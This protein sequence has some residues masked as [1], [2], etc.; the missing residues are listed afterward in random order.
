MRWPKIVLI[1]LTL[2]PAFS[3]V[4][5]GGFVQVH[6][7]D[8]GGQGDV[9]LD[10]QVEADLWLWPTERTWGVPWIFQR[11]I[12]SAPYT[13]RLQVWDE[14]SWCLRLTV[15]DVLVTYADGTQERQRDS[16]VFDFTNWA[17][18]LRVYAL[19]PD[20][21]TRHAE[22]ELVITGYLTGCDREQMPFT[23]RTHGTPDFQSHLES[24]IDHYLI[25]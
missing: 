12:F 7:Y 18:G 9:A 14:Q 21:V 15:T 13:A 23:V 11:K 17:G 20:V 8:F 22:H 10:P 16:R 3:L 4:T 6:R 25:D 2:F 19:I 24:S 5:C 1:I